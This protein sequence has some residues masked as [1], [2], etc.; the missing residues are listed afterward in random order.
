MQ[1]SIRQPAD[2]INEYDVVIVGAGPAGLWAAKTL[3]KSNLKTLLIE[4]NQ[5]IGPKI[6]AGGLTFKDITNGIPKNILQRKFNEVFIKSPKQYIKIASDKLL[7]GTVNRQDLGQWMKKQITGDNIII[8]RDQVLNINLKQNELRLKSG[9]I[10]KYKYL[11]GADGSNSQVRNALGLKQNNVALAY[12]YKIKKV[13]PKLEVIINVDRFGPWYIWI[14]PHWDHT[15]I[16]TGC[17][18][19]VFSLKIN[20]R[21]FNKWLKENNIDVS[22]AEFQAW[23]INYDY[24]GFQFDNIFLVGDAGGFTSGLTG[25]GIFAAM[26]SGKEAAK[27]IIDPSYN[28]KE[29]NLLLKNKAKH[30]KIIKEVQSNSALMKI[31]I[32]LVLFFTKFRFISKILIKM[33]A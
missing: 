12:Q 2:K 4:K 29:L 1:N 10:I 6:C 23:K 26:T 25:E 14:F 9:Q 21:E 17:D 24:Q 22:Q 13:F 30:E 18:P 19:K 20:R 28:L 3:A 15:L 5:I 32:E 27:K 16:G 33:L 7:V 11:I 8:I 31:K